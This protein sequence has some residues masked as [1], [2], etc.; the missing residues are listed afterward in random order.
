[1]VLVRRSF[2]VGIAA[3][4]VALLAGGAGPAAGNGGPPPPDE[5]EQYL[6]E[7]VNRARSDPAA[8]ASRLGVSASLDH[9]ALPAL[10]PDFDVGETCRVFCRDV[11]DNFAM[12]PVA[13]RTDSHGATAF[14]RLVTVADY[15]AATENTLSVSGSEVN[16]AAVDSLHRKAFADSAD[17]GQMLNG[18]MWE[19]G[20]GLVPGSLGGKA[21]VLIERYCYRLLLS[22]SYPERVPVITGAIFHDWR[23]ADGFYT[24]YEGQG[25]VTV[26]ATRASPFAQVSTTTWASGGYALA[27]SDGTWTLSA[28]GGPLEGAVHDFPGPVVVDG[29]SVWVSEA[30]AG[31]I[32]SVPTRFGVISGAGKQAKTGGYTLAV[33]AGVFD[34][35]AETLPDDFVDTLVVAVDGVD[36]L[37]PGNRLTPKVSR[38]ATGAIVKLVLADVAKN[39]LTIDAK[40]RLFKLTVK[41]APGIDPTDGGVT[42][43]FRSTPFDADVS[44]VPVVTGTKYTLPTTEGT[45]ERN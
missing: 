34:T 23:K 21:S 45:L 10:R 35:F 26:T 20:V 38:D 19:I 11:L 24:P 39:K 31:K 22:P 36:L 9:D 13:P 44:V 7:L 33:K 4:L 15:A 43:S 5:H 1:M 42:I 27:V 30:V 37:G 40:K 8:E 29:G 41:N 14:D 17:R 12:I 2:F 18:A 32:P 6:V 28:T 3:L 16:T 25:G